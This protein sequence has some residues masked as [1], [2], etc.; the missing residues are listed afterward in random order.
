MAKRLQDVAKIHLADLGTRI[1]Y[2]EYGGFDTHAAQATAHPKLWGEV[3]TA[4]ADFWDD[5]KAHDAADKVTMLVFSEFGRRVKENGG[6]TD[7]G[8]AG[9]AFAIGPGVE[10]GTYGEYPSIEADKLVDG[11]LRPTVDFRGLYSSILNDWMG[12]DDREVL[13]REFERP[14]LFSN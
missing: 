8:A 12:L 10:G 4:I 14:A 11:D 5:L 6:G 7:H 2:T 3:S 9:V 1:L 13:P